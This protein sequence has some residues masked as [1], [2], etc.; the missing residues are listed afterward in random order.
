VEVTV[1]L[2]EHATEAPTI[3]RR[4]KINGPMHF[5]VISLPPE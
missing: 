3:R 2:F 4:Q 1:P 5:L